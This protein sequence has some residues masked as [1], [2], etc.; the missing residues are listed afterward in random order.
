MLDRFT[1]LERRAIAAT[2]VCISELVGFDG[3]IHGWRMPTRYVKAESLDL[4]QWRSTWRRLP[5]T[6]KGRVEQQ[7]AFCSPKGSYRSAGRAR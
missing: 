4:K 1:D 3:D 7:V 5:A 6:M 2:R